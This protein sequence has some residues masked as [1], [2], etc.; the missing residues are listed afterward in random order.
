MGAAC[1]SAQVDRSIRNPSRVGTPEV[2]VDVFSPSRGSNSSFTKWSRNIEPL[3]TSVDGSTTQERNSD[4]SC[5]EKVGVKSLPDKIVADLD[6][7]IRVNLVNSIISESPKFIDF[8]LLTFDATDKP[9]I[10]FTLSTRDKSS[11]G[12]GRDKLKAEW[13]ASR[14][15]LE[16]ASKKI[17]YSNHIKNSE[18][19]TRELFE[20]ETGNITLT[21]Q[22]Y[23]VTPLHENLLR[24][25]T[26]SLKNEE[27]H[28]TEVNPDPEPSSSDY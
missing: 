15:D 13:L 20:Q 17:A 9:N 12:T 28:E 10:A 18:L 2:N 3:D 22:T 27:S 5:I 25:S 21:R 1:N 8:G 7:S 14:H 16:K 23:L 4:F 6:P 26:D 24:R 11:N 19:E